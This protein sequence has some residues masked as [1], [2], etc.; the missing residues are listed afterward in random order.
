MLYLVAINPDKAQAIDSVKLDEDGTFKF[1]AANGEYPEFYSLVM[2]NHRIDLAIDSTETIRITADSKNMDTEYTV[3]GSECSNHIKEIIT[4]RNEV[5]TKILA[6]ENNNTLYPKEITDSILVMINEHKDWL[7]HNYIRIRPHEL[8]GYYALMQSITDISGTYSLFRP[9]Q[10]RNDAKCYATIATSWQMHFPNSQRTYKLCDTATK[11]MKHTAPKKDKVLE[12]DNEK[13]SETGII[14]ISLPDATGNIQNIK[15]LKDKVVLLDF[16]MYSAAESAQRNIM[17]R[18]LYSKYQ[19]KG[20]EIYQISLDDNISFWKNAVDKL[21]WVCVHETDGQ[22]T[23]AYGIQK[24]P[25][26]FLI[27]RNNEVVVRSDFMEGSLEDNIKK[28]L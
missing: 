3:E 28:L 24:L 10:D 13:I 5:E 4:K 16:T 20:L 11:A 6:V 22:V 21:P 23:T 26:F 1:K 25:T 14:N 7:M 27:N 19:I 9:Y 17:M 18:E 8:C 2:N 15:D 12:I